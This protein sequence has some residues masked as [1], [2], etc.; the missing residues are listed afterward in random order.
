MSYR[1]QM[2]SQFEEETGAKLP[3]FFQKKIGPIEIGACDKLAERT[4]VSKEVAACFM[5]KWCALPEYLHRMRPGAVRFDLDG[6][7]CGE[8]SEEHALKAKAR[9]K[10]RKKLKKQAKEK[11]QASKSGRPVLKLRGAAA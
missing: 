2:M 1:N 4:G 9:L 5:S 11:Q 7:P 3:A 8:V 6:E 10:G